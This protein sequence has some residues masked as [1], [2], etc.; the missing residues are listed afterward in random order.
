M[1]SL[2]DYARSL[3]PTG[4]CPWLAVVGWRK[5]AAISPASCA[6][7]A[8]PS[9]NTVFLVAAPALV[10]VTLHAHGLRMITVCQFETR[11]ANPEVFSW[12]IKLH[13]SRLS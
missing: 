4:S 7:L 9:C 13:T 1:V 8:V 11:I 3:L 6:N 2:V 12:C 10:L 5:N